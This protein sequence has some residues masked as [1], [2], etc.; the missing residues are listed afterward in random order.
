VARKNITKTITVEEKRFIAYLL[1]E[2]KF[3]E[4]TAKAYHQD[5]SEFLG[6]LSLNALSYSDVDQ[7]LIRAYLLD[8]INAGLAKSSI[9]R[10][11]A[12]L[13]H[14]YQFLYVK[15]LIKTDYFE[16]VTSPKQ[17]KKLPDFLTSEE[18]KK[19]FDANKKRTDKLAVRD[20][21]LLELMY[22]SGLRASEVVNLTLQ[23]VNLSERVVRVIGKG[24]KERIVPFT[25]GAAKAMIEY[26]NESRPVL[27][28]RNVSENKTN[29]FFVNNLGE[30]LTYRGLEYIMSEIE[31]K[32]GC[33]VKLHPHKLRHSFAT[34]LLSNGADLRTIQEMM[35]HESIGTTQVYTH[36][37]YS[38]MQDV[39]KNAFPRAKKQNGKD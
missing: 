18:V 29:C 32:T 23:S 37:T 3:S 15:D 14:F 7:E 34:H 27:M 38:E 6:F 24:K 10:H 13:K 9:K 39:Y 22:A 11:L 33:Y 31:K 17:D 28:Q 4:N 1:N 8:L 26:I 19:L 35:G 20:Q 36:V 12:A 16:S 2:R 5:V 30:K 25:R 21:A